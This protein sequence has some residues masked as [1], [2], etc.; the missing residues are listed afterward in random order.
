[1]T[2]ALTMVPVINWATNDGAGNGAS[3]SGSTGDGGSGSGGGTGGDA[4]GG[5]G[6]GGTGSGGDGGAGAGN[7]GGSGASGNGG[8]GDGKPWYDTRDWSDPALKDFAVKA[9]YHIGTADEALEKALK[10]EMNATAKL[11][12]NPASL[13]ELPGE[14][15]KVSDFLKANAAA[16]GV[17]DNIDNYE[18]T[19]PDDLP[20]GMPIDQAL[21]QAIKLGRSTLQF[22][23]MD[24]QS[25]PCRITEHIGA[26]FSDNCGV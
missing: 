9:G 3:G 19:L 4:G 11:G 22:R 13:A 21:M 8:A 24:W 1:M 2:T 14:D 20:E 12:K 23:D 25:M 16:L 7:G 10:G 18:L 6:D 5:A 15:G 17:P 26:V